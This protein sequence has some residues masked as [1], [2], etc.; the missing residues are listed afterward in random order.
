MNSRGRWMAIMLTPEHGKQLSH[1]ILMFTGH[2]WCALMQHPVV[3]KVYGFLVGPEREQGR[4]EDEKEP[5]MGRCVCV[6][7]NCDSTTGSTVAAVVRMM[8]LLFRS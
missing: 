6:H 5:L 7:A 3:A 8:P 2:S 1:L 4:K